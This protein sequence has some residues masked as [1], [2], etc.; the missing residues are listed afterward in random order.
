MEIKYYDER[1]YLSKLDNRERKILEYWKEKYKTNTELEK[2]NNVEL[3]YLYE[4]YVKLASKLINE[5]SLDNWFSIR[6][7]D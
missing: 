3:I 2:I 1:Y 4:E 7:I 5:I 6:Y